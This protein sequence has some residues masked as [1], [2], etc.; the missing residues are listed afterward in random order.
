MATIVD[1]WQPLESTV[2]QN[3]DPSEMALADELK[4]KLDRNEDGRV[5]GIMTLKFADHAG[6]EAE[7]TAGIVTT[8]LEAAVAANIGDVIF[9]TDHLNS[10][11]KGA[12]GVQIAIA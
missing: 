11:Q 5:F 6:L 7:W 3:G 8:V 12:I 1:F 9:P 4:V 2:D 10:L